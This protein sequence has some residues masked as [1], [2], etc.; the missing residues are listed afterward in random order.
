[1]EI[2]FHSPNGDEDRTFLEIQAAGE[3]GSMTQ[4]GDK[5]GQSVSQFVL[6]MYPSLH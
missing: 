6:K 4:E 3:V 1:M 2:C 5:K